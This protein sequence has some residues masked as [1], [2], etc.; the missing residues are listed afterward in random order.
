MNMHVI[1]FVANYVTLIPGIYDRRDLLSYKD[2][3]SHPDFVFNFKEYIGRDSE[4]FSDCWV[5][6][7]VW[8]KFLHLNLK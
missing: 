7:R 6:A 4:Q 8:A 1:C 5:S 2:R 3:P